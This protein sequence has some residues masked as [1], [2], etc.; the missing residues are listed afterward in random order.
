MSDPKLAL[1]RLLQS[2]LDPEARLAHFWQ[3]NALY[4]RGEHAQAAEAFEK[5]IARYPSFMIARFHLGVIYARQGDDRKAK[6][7]FQKLLLRNPD[8]VAAR[9]YV[10]R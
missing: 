10:A 8:D 2:E 7:Q 1:D 5:L 9:Y 3:G 4:H 6:E